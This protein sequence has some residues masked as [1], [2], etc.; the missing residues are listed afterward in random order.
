MSLS[1]NSR[2]ISSNIVEILLDQPDR[3]CRLRFVGIVA[4]FFGESGGKDRDLSLS[5]RVGH[6]NGVS[7]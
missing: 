5:S 7:S 3:T 1:N 2:L 6:V 4:G